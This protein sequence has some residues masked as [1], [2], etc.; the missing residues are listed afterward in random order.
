MNVAFLPVYP[1]PYQKLLRDALQLEGIGIEFLDNLPPEDWLR[2]QRSWID[3]LHYHWLDGLYMMRYRTPLQVM[4]FIRHFHTARSL[5]YRT[6]WTAHN[7]L[8][9]RPI[10]LPL[11][12]RIRRLMMNEADAV[13][14]HCEHGRRELMARFPRRGPVVVIPHGH[15]RDV[16]PR[17]FS[18]AAARERLGLEDS[19]FIYLSFGNITAYKGLGDFVHAFQRVASPGDV[20]LIAGRDRDRRLVSRLSEISA[21][22]ARIHIKPGF[23]P[24]EEVALYHAAADVAVAPFRRVLTSG[25]V[26]AALSFGLPVIAP[27]LGCLPELIS[28]A[29]GL[30][31]EAD[32]PAAL[33]SALREIKARDLAEMRAAARQIADGLDW[34]PIARRTAGVYQSCLATS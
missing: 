14:T 28:P 2:S 22:D 25:S 20:A 17:T 26:I 10:F 3:I 21:N 30:L 23:V 9:H 11:H 4:K 6:V 19:N 1:N 27:A 7:I 15:Y 32:K 33:D 5:G 29:A 16:Y 8:P 13:I 31:Y 24:E 12:K 18:R 34:R